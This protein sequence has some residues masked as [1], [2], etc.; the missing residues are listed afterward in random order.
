MKKQVTWI[1]G[2]GLALVVVSFTPGGGIQ[3]ALA[4]DCDPRDRTE[5]PDCVDVDWSDERDTEGSLGTC[6]VHGRG[7]CEYKPSITNNCSDGVTVKADIFQK[8]DSKEH[9]EPGDNW[10]VK[11]YYQ[12]HEISFWC[13]KPPEESDCSQ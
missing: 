12:K 1:I 3:V 5:L 6:S 13:C 4:D 10:T 2:L 8:R 11:N 9:L 7:S